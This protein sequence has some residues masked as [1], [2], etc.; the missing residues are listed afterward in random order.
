MRPAAS[1]LGALGVLERKF[2]TAGFRDVEAHILSLPVRMSTA[3][4]C[5]LYLKNTSPTLRELLAPCSPQ[6]RQEAWQ[7][8]EAALSVY[9]GQSNFEVHHRIIVAAGS[10]A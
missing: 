5:V 7:E 6:E 8:V 3:T 9:Q 10:A 2:E 4:E 1:S